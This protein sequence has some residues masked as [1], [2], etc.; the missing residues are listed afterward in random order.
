MSKKKSASG[1]GAPGGAGGGSASTGSS[2]AS[3]P[4]AHLLDHKELKTLLSLLHDDSTKLDNAA[5]AFQKAFGRNDRFRL[6]CVVSVLIQDNMLSRAERI[7]AFYVLVDLYRN[8]SSG[9][10][11]FLPVFL[12]ALDKRVDVCE[13]NFLVHLLCSPPSNR[14]AAKKSASEIISEFSS[15]A[16]AMDMPDVN[17]LWKDYADRTPA[18]RNTFLSASIR[19]VITDTSVAPRGPASL[20]SF[21]SLPG[22]AQQV[23]GG[24]NASGSGLQEDASAAR[25]APGLTDADLNSSLPASLTLRGFEPEFIRLPPPLVDLPDD[26]QWLAPVALPGLLWDANMC[27]DTT[28]S[29]ELR[30]LMKVAFT[31]SLQPEQVKQIK[32]ELEANPK[33]VF[34]CGLE[35]EKF[36]LCARRPCPPPPAPHN[37]SPSTTQCCPP[38]SAH[39]AHPQ[40]AAPLRTRQTSQPG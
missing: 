31:T 30:E 4:Q 19:P 11:P 22:T 9:T 10:N 37:H 32:Q 5:A 27:E 18:V 33:L 14:E 6:G 2:G 3:A 13:K 28:R 26:M 21:P 17:A 23:G 34:H 25:D 20:A 24:N 38:P 29:A 35:P 8:E 16:M 1:A 7:V 12:E 39:R 40:A 15:A 36:V